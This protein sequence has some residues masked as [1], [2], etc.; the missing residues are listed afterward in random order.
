MLLLFVFSTRRND[1][2]LY[3]V[4]VF[5]TLYS[6]CSTHYNNR[7]RLAARRTRHTDCNRSPGGELSP[8]TLTH[9]HDGFLLFSY[10]IPIRTR[11]HTGSARACSNICVT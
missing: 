6:V 8:G 4:V 5:S 10:Y 9:T 1:N 2:M 11:F 7:T 3:T